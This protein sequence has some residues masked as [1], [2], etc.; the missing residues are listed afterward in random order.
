MIDGGAPIWPTKTRDYV[1]Y[2]QEKA[3]R[4]LG[5]RL[6]DGS[7]PEAVYER[8][9][10]G[11]GAS[12]KQTPEQVRDELKL[13]G[14]F[15]PEDWEQVKRRI[16]EVEEIPRNFP[17][18]TRYEDQ[19]MY[20]LMNEIRLII[21]ERAA[22]VARPIKLPPFLATLPSGDV[23]AQIAFAPEKQ[24]AGS[25]F[26]TRSG[27][28]STQFLRAC[29]LGDADL[30]AGRPRRSDLAISGHSTTI[31]PSKWLSSGH[32]CRLTLS[33]GIRSPQRPF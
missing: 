12:E 33:T 16:K 1:E 30:A 7:S 18:P 5:D 19:R 21:I 25:V 9:M 13:T 15:S 31:A 10:G 32:P 23:N 28:V 2:Q 17:A 26:R 27:L 22:K 6:G 3:Y 24:T 29:Q 8:L 20:K 14:K 11:R 4:E